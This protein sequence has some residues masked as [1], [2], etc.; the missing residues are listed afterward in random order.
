MRIVGGGDDKAMDFADGGRGGDGGIA[1]A[2][3]K[4]RDPTPSKELNTEAYV[5]LL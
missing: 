5:E 3:E 4:A 2:R 1:G